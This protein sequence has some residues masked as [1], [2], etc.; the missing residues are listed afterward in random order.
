MKRMLIGSVLTLAVA[1]ACLTGG[2]AA[3]AQEAQKKG[4]P[5]AEV[6]LDREVEK[7]GGLAAFQKVQTVAIKGTLSVQDVKGR[8]VKYLAA[9]NKSYLEQSI[10][11]VF[12]AETVVNGDLAWE[13][14]NI[15][16]ARL[17]EGKDR[18]K[19]LRE[20]DL[21]NAANWRSRYK[22]VKTVGE[23]QVEGKAAYKVQMTT[24]DG[25]VVTAHYDKQ[26]GLQVRYEFTVE[27]PQGNG[28]VVMYYSNH[29]RVD[30]IVVPFTTRIVAGPVEVVV[31]ID[32][33]QYN[34]PIPTER[35]TPPP[36]VQNLLQKQ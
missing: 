20:A 4:L 13:K 12:T 26:S 25:E 6:L 22:E 33:I 34:V 16:G 14:D 35:F 29:K 3:T 1:A 8:I 23:E 18:A 9:P 5:S 11:G 32:E 31:T 30:G 2:Q 7:M 15:T 36:E 27:S 19:A 28:T 10:E 17:L 24:V 21:L